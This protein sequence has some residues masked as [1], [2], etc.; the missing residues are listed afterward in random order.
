[1]LDD[2][3][4][5]L[6]AVPQVKPQSKPRAK[7]RASIRKAAKNLEDT[8]VTARIVP[9]DEWKARA[10]AAADADAS[11]QLMRQGS[12][13]EG[14]DWGCVHAGGSRTGPLLS[15]CRRQQVTEEH[16]AIC[17]EHIRTHNPNA[18]CYD[19]WALTTFFMGALL[20]EYAALV[21]S[22]APPPQSRGLRSR[23]SPSRATPAAPH[24]SS[25]RRRRPAAPTEAPMWLLWMD[26]IEFRDREGKLVACS[27]FARCGAGGGRGRQQCACCFAR[28]ERVAAAHDLRRRDLERRP[29]RL[30]RGVRPLRHLVRGEPK[31][32]PPGH[33]AAAPPLTPARAPPPPPP[34]RRRPLQRL[35]NFAMSL[36]RACATGVRV[37]N[38]GPTFASVKK[39][40]SCCPH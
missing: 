31:P 29:L 32:P 20:G 26:M 17:R 13:E 38:A 35:T 2:T 6:R 25:S 9:A 7:L 5:L 30:P 22:P 40:A 19:M 21:A 8:G 34:P 24:S 18:G 12:G 36:E 14:E 16:K 39:G 3:T 1:M 33:R 4:R 28:A 11:Q 15:L 27:W 10:A 23:S 37:V